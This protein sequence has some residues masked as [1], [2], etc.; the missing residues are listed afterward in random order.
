M[1]D[2]LTGAVFWLAML[3]FLSIVAIL[4][5]LCFSNKEHDKNLRRF[6]IYNFDEDTNNE[7]NV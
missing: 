4:S 7:K 2:L 6:K 3:S 5:I 1:N